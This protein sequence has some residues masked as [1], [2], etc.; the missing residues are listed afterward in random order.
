MTVLNASP[1]SLAISRE[2]LPDAMSTRTSRSRWLR[3]PVE[4]ESVVI[5]NPAPCDAGPYTSSS[6]PRLRGVRLPPSMCGRVVSAEASHDHPVIPAARW[7]QPGAHALRV[8][9][10]E[11]HRCPSI[12][13]FFRGSRATARV[14]NSRGAH[15]IKQREQ[16]PAAG[17]N[18]NRNLRRSDRAGWACERSWNLYQTRS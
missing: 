7:R 12:S 15:G 2:L 18:D 8:T 10:G 4:C 1:R 9:G 14:P 16:D 11:F 3:A 13:R 5:L 6:A 17:Q